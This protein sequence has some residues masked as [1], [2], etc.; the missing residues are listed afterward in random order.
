[1][2]T[3]RRCGAP[4]SVTE[5]RSAPMVGSSEAI[6]RRRRCICGWSGTTYEVF[7]A[8]AARPAR[9]MVMVTADVAAA[10]DVIAQAVRRADRSATTSTPTTPPPKDSDAA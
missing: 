6:R 3:C 5:T 2:L 8:D 4:T 10:L 9:G 7:V 1:M